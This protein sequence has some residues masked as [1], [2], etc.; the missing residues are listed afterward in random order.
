MED[1][2]K[3]DEEKFDEWCSTIPVLDDKS[4]SAVKFCVKYHTSEYVMPQVI[5]SML[6]ARPPWEWESVHSSL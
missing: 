4:P 3:N 5:F 2:R 1:T 6:K